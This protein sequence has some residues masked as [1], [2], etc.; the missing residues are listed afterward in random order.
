M[1]QYQLISHL[2]HEY[3]ALKSQKINLSPFGR[4]F[5]IEINLTKSYYKEQEEQ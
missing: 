1:N 4:T 5:L 3:L 2:Y